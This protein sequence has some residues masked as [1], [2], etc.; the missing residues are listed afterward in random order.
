MTPDPDSAPKMNPA[1]L[2]DGITTTHSAL[3]QIASGIPLSDAFRISE[4]TSVACV[5][6]L[7]SFESWADAVVA[8]SSAAKAAI[9]ILRKGICHLHPTELNCKSR[10][11]TP[12]PEHT[13]ESC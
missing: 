7:A 12:K 1:F 11:S 9:P 10:C 5:S 13:V 2:S 4:R 3:L 8:T 6:R